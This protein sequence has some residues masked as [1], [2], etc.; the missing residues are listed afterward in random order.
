MK[1]K[2]I[3]FGVLSA[4]L[5]SG[6]AT[7]IGDPSQSMT[8]NSSPDDA[9]VLIKD[10][11]GVEIFKGNTPTTVTLQK[12]DGSYWGGK[13]YTVVISKDGFKEQ[14]IPVKSSPNGWYIAGNLVFGGLI[15]W[16]IVDPLN[17]DMYTLSP[18]AVSASLPDQTAH[19]NAANDGNIRVVLLKDVPDEMRDRLVKLN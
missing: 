6:C 3:A 1:M 12:S 7:I 15:G 10:E 5:V 4:Y 16:F 2:N 9:R 18:Q 17:G 19:N 11:K 13:D 14:S 8:I